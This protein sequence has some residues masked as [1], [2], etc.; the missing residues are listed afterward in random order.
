[1][2]D[3]VAAQN[4]RD[5]IAEHGEVVEVNLD[6]SGEIEAIFADGHR[7]VLE[8][9]FKFG[10]E[11]TGPMCF[12]AWLR[13]AGFEATEE[14]VAEMRAP[15]TLRPPGRAAEPPPTKATPEPKAAMRAPCPHCAK[16]LRIPLAFAS[17]DVRC[18]ACGKVFRAP[19][20]Q[21]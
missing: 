1:V 14:D 4:A 18:R 13:A 21:N 16:L 6:T 7:Q 10:Y 2:Y 19:T 11:G 17:K 5:L 12:A 20:A 8:P 3:E 9:M 15:L